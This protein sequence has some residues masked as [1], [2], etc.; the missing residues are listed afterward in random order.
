MTSYIG[1][2]RVS[3]PVV[4]QRDYRACWAAC[5]VMVCRHYRVPIDE[6][7]EMELSSGQGGQ[8]GRA[9][10][11][12]L[13]GIQKTDIT[14]FI[15]NPI[16]VDPW[17]EVL[18]YLVAS[19]HRRQPVILGLRETGKPPHAVV[20]IGADLEERG[21]FTKVAIADPSA[22]PYWPRSPTITDLAR[23]VHEAVFVWDP[24]PSTGEAS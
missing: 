4:K 9:I 2:A 19:F 11:D 12:R 13:K 6:R 20:A 16:V 14:D 5:L 22:P 18:P 21:C 15:P 24:M 1:I 8:S 17:K 3:F 7:S 23:A 10:A